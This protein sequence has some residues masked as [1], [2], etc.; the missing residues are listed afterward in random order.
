MSATVRAVVPPGTGFGVQLSGIDIGDAAAMNVYRGTDPQ[1]LERIVSAA[2]PSLTFMDTGLSLAEVR[3]P[4]DP[5]FEQARFYWRWE[6]QPPVNADSW[7]TVTI[8]NSTL[9]MGVNAVAG[10]TVRIVGAT[11]AGQER[12]I[13]SNTGSV[14]TVTPSW[15]VQPGATSQFA[16][17]ES[18]WN[19]ATS[20]KGSPVSFE[21]SNRPGATIQVMAR[22]AS[23]SGVESDGSLSPVSRWQIEGD[24]GSS[25]DIGVP[26]MPLFS[27]GLTG[28]GSVELTGIGFA[29]LENTRSISSG[30]LLLHY[31]N[32]VGGIN[33]YSLVSAAGPGDTVVTVNAAGPGAVGTLLQIGSELLEITGVSGTAYQVARGKFGTAA[34]S[35]AA[36]APVMHLT[37]R[38]EIVAFPNEFF[39]SPA[40]GSYAYSVD[41][42]SVRIAAAELF[43]SNS[44]GISLTRQIAYTG[45]SDF[46]LRTLS[47]GQYSIQV[48]GLLAIQESAA[49]SV[50]VEASHAVRDIYARVKQAPTGSP[51]QMTL[52]QN[53]ALYCNL[54]IAT[55]ATISNVVSGVVAGALWSQ[56]A[57]T[58]DITSVGTGASDFPGQDLTV[59]IRL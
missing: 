7:S 28:R 4:P 10:K 37:R 3:V 29:T 48:E 31:W 53:G 55:G 40:S 20:G 36:S 45:L 18:G 58:L 56:S 21:V 17:V 57:L 35:H 46:G 15:S 51:V 27:L 54:T 19:F 14:L 30:T 44:R 25:L 5:N 6:L 50:V 33:P 8:G 12:R 59:T 49:P 9:S 24:A 22:A 43:V 47:G 23:A 1:K 32:E 38:V 13:T 41:L 34:L 11:G 2:S 52:R 39:G 42:P 26:P 16:I